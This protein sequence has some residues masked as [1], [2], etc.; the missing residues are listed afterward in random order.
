MN[1][2]KIKTVISKALELDIYFKNKC[3]LS[4]YYVPG[5]VL[6]LVLYI[7]IFNPHHRPMMKIAFSEHKTCKSSHDV[8]L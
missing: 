4:G 8:K 6:S 1:T 7:I 3:L 2:V 5:I